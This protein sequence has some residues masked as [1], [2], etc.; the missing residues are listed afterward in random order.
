[1]ISNVYSKSVL[2]SSPQLHRQAEI[3]LYDRLLPFLSSPVAA[4]KNSG[5]DVLEIWNSVS[6]DFVT[7]YQF[8]L[9]NG[10]NFLR[11]VEYRRHWLH[12]Y[13][14]RKTYP[15]FVQELPRLTSFLKSF[16][17]HLV[18][19]WVDDANNELEAWTKSRC[20]DTIE[21]LNTA[22]ADDKEIAN[23]PVVMKALLAGMDKERK[24]K[25]DESVLA[26]TLLENPELS[27]PSEMIDQL[28][29]GHETSAITLTYLAWELSRDQSLQDALR[30]EL[31]TL[32]PNMLLGP[33]NAARNIPSSKDIDNLPILDAV[34]METLRLHAAIP[35]GQPRMTPYPSCSLGP[36]HI[37]GGVRVG[38]QAHSVHRNPTIY[39]EPE[40]FI[41]TR[42]M[43]DRNG[44]A[45]DQSKERD[46]WFWAFS[47]GGRMCIGSNFALHGT[48]AAS[49][50]ILY[51]A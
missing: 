7:A 2:Q 5:V 35:G 11:D 20:D 34:V 17:I 21:Y 39:P 43:D 50:L 8:G 24:T 37:P 27:I 4:D 29:A 13:Y 41:Y 47:S 6:L 14:A 40:K 26:D 32:S 16:H 48:L 33:S 38:A 31:L 12:L 30:Q 25:G 22:A 19:L 42:W 10:S 28:A 1:M 15:Y 3:I 9:K 46:R 45:E 44:Y 49:M 36:Y 51:H 23:E 18:P